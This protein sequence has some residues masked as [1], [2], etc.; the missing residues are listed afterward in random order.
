[1]TR[2]PYRTPWTTWMTSKTSK[3][4]RATTWRTSRTSTVTP[5]ITYRNTRAT[6]EPVPFYMDL[7]TF[8]S[9][10]L[11]W[12]TARIEPASGPLGTKLTT[13]RTPRTSWLTTR[14]TYRRTWTSQRTTKSSLDLSLWSLLVLKG[15]THYMTHRMSSISRRTLSNDWRTTRTTQ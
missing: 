13:S 6:L 2:T 11:T 10:H 7:Q 9:D 1:M 15:Q 3:K 14:T 5:K 12:R 8:T 4:I